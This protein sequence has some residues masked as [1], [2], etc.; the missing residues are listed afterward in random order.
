MPAIPL[1]SNELDVVGRYW[2]HVYILSVDCV[3]SLRG[4][5]IG[6]KLILMS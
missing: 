4:S 5:Y 2:L 6:V 3:L 1:Q